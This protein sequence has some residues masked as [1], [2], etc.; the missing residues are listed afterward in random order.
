LSPFRALLGTPSLSPSFCHPPAN[1]SCPFGSRPDRPR[2]DQIAM[3]VD[4]HAGPWLALPRL[5]GRRIAQAGGHPRFEIAS[6]TGPARITNGVRPRWTSTSNRLAD[7][8]F[9]SAGACGGD[10]HLDSRGHRGRSSSRRR[11]RVRRMSLARKVRFANLRSPPRPPATPAGPPAGPP[12]GPPSPQGPSTQEEQADAHRL[13]SPVGSRQT[14]RA[15]W[16]P[17]LPP[18]ISGRSRSMDPHTLTGHAAW[19]CF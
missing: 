7:P 3:T 9:P 12:G 19:R 15:N 8:G 6:R 2:G 4:G 5:R 10:T 17:G 13:E 1:L 18:A 14:R 16:P 11:S